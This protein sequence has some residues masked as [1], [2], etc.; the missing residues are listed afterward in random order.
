VSAFQINFGSS[1]IETAGDA[2]DVLVAM[3]PAALKVNVDQLKPGGLVIADS[4]EFG[5]RNLAKAGYSANPL[6][7]ARSPAGS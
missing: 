2:P 5:A 6:K 3:N 7:M 4:G 1:A